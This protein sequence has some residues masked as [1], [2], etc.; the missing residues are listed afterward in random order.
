[1]TAIIGFEEANDARRAIQEY[2]GFK[3]HSFNLKRR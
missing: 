2:D 1:M 3:N